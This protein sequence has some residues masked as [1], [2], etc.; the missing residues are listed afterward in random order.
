MKAKRNGA[1]TLEQVVEDT[2]NLA[3]LVDQ[4]V[5]SQAPI[6]VARGGEPKAALV[7]L[8]D[9]ARLKQA[10]AE[11]EQKV[12]WEEWFARNQEFHESMLARRGGKPLEKEIVDQAL[13]AARQELE[14]RDARHGSSGR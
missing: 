6:V 14:E 7:S 1:T 12:S 9:Y 8:E 5:E 2:G 10:T 3:R 4:V 11:R 13:Q